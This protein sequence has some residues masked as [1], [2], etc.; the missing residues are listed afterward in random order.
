MNKGRVSREKDE[1]IIGNE[2]VDWS[3]GN[4]RLWLAG[5]LNERMN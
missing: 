2:G 4:G 3:E 1:G 5:W